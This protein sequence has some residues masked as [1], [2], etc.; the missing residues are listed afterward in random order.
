MQTHD[1][2]TKN[3][4][5]RIQPKLWLKR[6][7]EV[8]GGCLVMTEKD[9]PEWVQSIRCSGSVVVRPIVIAVLIG[10]RKDRQINDL[11]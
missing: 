10:V 1:S 3:A 5:R 2:A 4:M 7:R 8:E 11:R 9:R 6:G